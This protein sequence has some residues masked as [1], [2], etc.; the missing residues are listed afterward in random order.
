MTEDNAFDFAGRK[1]CSDRTMKTLFHQVGCYCWI[2]P[3]HEQSFRQQTGAK[4]HLLYIS[5][6][7]FHS[8][9]GGIRKSFTPPYSDEFHLKFISFHS[10]KEGKNGNR[11]KHSSLITWG[12]KR[13]CTGFNARSICIARRLSD[14]VP[15][16][17]MLRLVEIYTGNYNNSTD[18]R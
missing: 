1:M 6:S 2:H 7:G 11:K 9:C 16:G 14:R 13:V 5:T 4:T 10:Y 18:N 12:M 15:K 3:Q 8:R 17:L